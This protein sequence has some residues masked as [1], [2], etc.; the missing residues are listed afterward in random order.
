[1]SL[2]NK[3]LKFVTQVGQ[4]WNQLVYELNGWLVFGRELEIALNDKR[5]ELV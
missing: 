3:A 2:L 1:M 4:N 5:L